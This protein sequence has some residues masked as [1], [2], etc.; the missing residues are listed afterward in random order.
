MLKTAEI[1]DILRFDDSIRS[2]IALEMT[3]S[4]PIPLRQAVNGRNVL[5]AQSF[6]FGRKYYPEFE[7]ADLYPP[8][9][10]VRV[11]WQTGDVID[12]EE[13]ESDYF[14]V[15][16]DRFTSF[17]TVSYRSMADEANERQLGTVMERLD[18]LLE[19]YDTVV[20][21]WMLGSAPARGSANQFQSLFTSLVEP[22]LL[23]VYRKLG[24]DFFGWIRT[25]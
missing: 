24:S 18:R 16:R 8:S 9:W 5:F 4:L 19:L 22:P 15:G 7:K 20:D 13:K 2:K 11:N 17:A 1:N 14:G 6:Y 25:G 12:I 21:Q 10:K 23:P 3:A